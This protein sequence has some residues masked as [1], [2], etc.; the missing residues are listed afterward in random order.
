MR[1][2]SDGSMFGSE[3]AEAV[4]HAGCSIARRIEILL[5]RAPPEPPRQP[6]QDDPHGRRHL[7]RE[8]E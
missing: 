1:D 3:R 7:H 6:G 2:N 8:A 5:T 4:G